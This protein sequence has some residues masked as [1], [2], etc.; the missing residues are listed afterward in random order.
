[1]KIKLVI[2]LLGLSLTLNAKEV[3]K[4]SP[5]N[6][7]MTEAVRKA[8]ENSSDKDIKLVFEQGTYLFMPDY[9]TEKYCI[10]TNHGNGLKKIIFNFNGFDSVEVEG[11][12]S[13]YRDGD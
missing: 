6:G 2:L 13:E 5:S 12:G 8:L 3:L 4:F 11:N 9:A 1:M 7:D 10:I